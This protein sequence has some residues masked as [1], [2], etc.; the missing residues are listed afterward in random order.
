PTML[1]TPA[2]VQRYLSDPQK[3]CFDGAFLRLRP[4]AD[5]RRVSDALSQVA[6]EEDD[7]LFIQDQ[8]A[9]YANVRRS[10]QP[11]VDAL[12]LFALADLIGTALVVTQLLGRQLREA[13]AALPVWRALGMDR[14]KM[15]LVVAVPAIVSAAIGVVV[16]I[17]TAVALSGRFPIGP[18][19][20][21]ETSRGLHVDVAVV[22][23]GM[24]FAMALPLAVGA[25]VGVIAVRDT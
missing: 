7:E 8:R 13:G 6:H 2:F 17:G 16:A 22:M 10:I 5:V 11:Q 3:W 18:A 19:R 20:L 24:L 9:S 1:T 23:V 25:V 4:G 21:A 12:W 15:R 14:S